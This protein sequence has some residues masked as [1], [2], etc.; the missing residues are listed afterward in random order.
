MRKILLATAAVLLTIPAYAKDSKFPTWF[1]R[2]VK[3]QVLDIRNNCTELT[4]NKYPNEMQ[5]VTILDLKGDG[6][7]DI[8]V[9]SE[10]LCGDWLAGGNCSNRFCDLYSYKEGP[11][12]T[13]RKILNEEEVSLLEKNFL[14]FDKRTRKF[15]SMR[16]KISAADSRCDPGPNPSGW[17]WKRSCEVG[18]YLQER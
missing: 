5:G 4:K 18:R 14:S 3:N 13:W 6:S 11:K 2:E 7:R 8:I 1:P 10:Q 17:L 16:I 15:Q 12:G 9:S